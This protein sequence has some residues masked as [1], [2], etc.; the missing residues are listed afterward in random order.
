MHFS[1]DKTANY[2]KLVTGD[3]NQEK[4][5]VCEV[6]KVGT[7]GKSTAVECME[8][9]DISKGAF[10]DNLHYPRLHDKLI[11]LKMKLTL[12]SIA[13]RSTQVDSK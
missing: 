6:R 13:R 9:W 1:V 2:S 8:L 10:Y 11:A 3:C 7:V 4:Y 12:C 5:F